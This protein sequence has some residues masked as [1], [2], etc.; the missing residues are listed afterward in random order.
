MHIFVFS[1]HV[2]IN[3]VT[4]YLVK[5]NCSD[6]KPESV[7]LHIIFLSLLAMIKVREC[8][9]EHNT[10]CN[11]LSVAI[12]FYSDIPE[13]PEDLPDGEEGYDLD[14]VSYEEEVKEEIGEVKKT[15]I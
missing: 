3:T 11:T 15:C 9:Y 13:I 7:G 12:T 1:Q 14:D 5:K 4:I 8:T 6:H 10:Y 2:V